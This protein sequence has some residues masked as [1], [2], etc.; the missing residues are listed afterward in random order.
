MTLNILGVGSASPTPKHNPSGQIITYRG[1]GYMIDC[2]EGSQRQMMCMGLS[3]HIIRHVFLSH[4]HGDHCLGLVPLLSSMGL[5]QKGGTVTIHTFA[6]GE[7]IFKEMI[8]FFCGKPEFN[9]EFNIIDPYRQQLLVDTKGLTIES[10]PLYHRV[11]TVGFIFREKPKPRHIIGSMV[12]FYN[13]PVWERNAIKQGA[14]FITSDGTV[15][16][17]EMLTTSPTPSAGYAYCSDTIFNKRVA[18]RVAGVD[19]LY[20][21]STYGDDCLHKAAPRGHSTARQAAEIAQLAG[22]GQLLLGHFS[23]SSNEAVMLSQ[24]REVFPSTEL[25][26]EGMVKVITPT[27]KQ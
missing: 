21:E 14:D 26:Y 3:P 18:R 1:A 20:H 8:D 17:N 15:I 22:A 27:L 25:A 16:T 13:V 2:G 5:N 12:E 23:K 6:E 7:R 4:L 10:F 11:P 24:A 9:I 19:V